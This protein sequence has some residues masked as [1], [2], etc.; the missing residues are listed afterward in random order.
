[1]KPV[2][3]IAIA[4]VLIIGISVTSISAQTNYEIPSWVKTN[5]IWWGE[6]QISDSD[7]LSA[8]QYLINKGHVTK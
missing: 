2:V 4:V 7:F 8:L 1:M 6:G 5:A 3:I